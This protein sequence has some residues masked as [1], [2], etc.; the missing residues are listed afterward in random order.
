M[1]LHTVNKCTSWHVNLYA[2]YATY[3]TYVQDKHPYLNANVAGAAVRGAR[4]AIESTG[5]APLWP[6]GHA[7]DLEAAVQQ[8][9][10]AS[11]WVIGDH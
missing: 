10:Q 11:L 4:G 5:G 9:R 7:P 2:S 3:A 8:R 1:L 6:D